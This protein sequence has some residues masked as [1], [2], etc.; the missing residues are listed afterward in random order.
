MAA[1]IT[2]KMGMKATGTYTTIPDHDVCRLSYYLRCGTV[3]CG[4]DI[5]VDELLDYKKAHELPRVRQDAIFRLA[6]D[7]FDLDTLVNTTIFIDDENDL[8]PRGTNNEFY[9]VSKVSNILAVQEDILIGGEH[10]QVRKIMVCNKRWLEKFYVNPLQNNLERI[11]PDA[12]NISL[13]GLLGALLV[14][15]LIT[16]DSNNESN[17]HCSHC[18]GGSGSCACNQGCPV[19]SSTQCSAA[20]KHCSHCKGLA[21]ICSCTEGCP[22]K[23]DSLC[24]VIHSGV[25]CDSCK[26]YSIEGPRYKC[27]TC[28]NYDLCESCYNKGAHKAHPFERYARVGS[29]STFLLA[30]EEPVS[31]KHCLHCNGANGKCKCN[32]GCVATKDSKCIVVHD[33]TCR[34]CL[35]LGIRGPCYKCSVCWEFHLCQK[36]YDAGEHVLTHSFLRFA[37]VGSRPVSMVPRSPSETP[38]PK[39]SHPQGNEDI[40][41]ATPVTPIKK[42]PLHEN[43]MPISVEVMPSFEKGM[44]VTLIN[45]TSNPA[46]NGTSAIVVMDMGNRVVVEVQSLS[47]KITVKPENLQLASSLAEGT[48]VEFKHLNKAEM[49][50]KLA[51]VSDNQVNS[52]GRIKVKLLDDDDLELYIKLENLNI[53]EDM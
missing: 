8:L 25:C 16:D 39:S 19:K 40:P 28:S 30:Q 31:H 52:N 42:I 3:S 5:I 53:I 47:K 2:E 33:A 49:N 18:K 6:Y 43:M 38:E 12:D 22:A 35:I 7:D 10:R 32:Q 23:P 15:S 1:I 20:R 27:N 36:C 13:G 50:G 29:T 48:L 41:I 11:K 37:R 26:T 45:M 44:V 14:A 46:M 24:R 21:S 4:L 17:D 34:S 9:E 51:V